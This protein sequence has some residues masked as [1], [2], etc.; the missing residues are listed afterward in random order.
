MKWDIGA[1]FGQL[2]ESYL[3]LPL[4]QKIAAP[5]LFVGA[6]M[7]LV[8][9][10]NWATRPD[11]RTLFSG[12]SEADA[13]AVVEKLKDQKVAYRLDND[14]K[15]IAVS[16]PHLVDEIRIE[17]AS[18]G[19]PKGGSVGLEIF[20]A[21]KLG[22]TG[23][24][25]EL[26]AL[27]GVQGE[28]ERTIGAIDAVKSVRVHITKPQRSSF[29]KRDVLPTASVLLRMKVGAELTK[30]QIKGIAHLVAGS[31][32]RL[33]PENV[34]IL[35]AKGNL[36]NAKEEQ[37]ELGGT[38]VTRLDYKN[39]IERTYAQQIESMLVGVLGTG[40]AIARVTADLDFSK[41]EKEE[42]QF[43]P[44]SRVTRSERSIEEGA[45][46]SAEGG[47]PGVLSNL[48]NDPGLLTPPDSAK[49]SKRSELVRNYEVSRA[50]SKVISAPGRVQKLSVAVLV[51]GMYDEVP[52]GAKTPEGSP[53]MEKQ[54]KPL[55]PEMI[56]K[57]EN[58]VKQ[59]VGFDSARGDIVTVEN[60]KFAEPD[61]RIQ[62]ILEKPD[63]FTTAESWARLVGP[64]LLGIMFLLI[65]VRPLMKFVLSP[66][67]AEVDLSRLLPAGLEELEAELEAERQKVSS[68]P[69]IQA[70]AV[71]IEE[72]EGLLSE[73]SRL[74]K[75]NPQQ[76][77][78][79]IR[80]WLNDG[81]V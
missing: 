9:V 14:G 42:E 20:D 47:V 17:L 22:L 33:T 77:A 12:L 48:T 41:F 79:L 67:E 81:R 61:D 73:N 40:K 52:T 28:L 54:Y 26:F 5:L 74:V 4:S 30:P 62:E 35:D 64:V 11:Y 18:A 3:K 65:L 72:L 68:M 15:S 78:L 50:V 75:E 36:L 1:V 34:T 6:V 60:M 80:L 2:V 25:E 45:G 71:D 49:A 31:V 56:K 44:A 58:L 8:F 38:E 43:D 76:A 10:S 16:P 53:V 24:Q 32:E 13:S 69:T 51:D 59:S 66:T 63:F 27:R 19:L 7:T 29:V 37:D 21:T 57:I 39:R 70:P 46:G 23:F 55:P